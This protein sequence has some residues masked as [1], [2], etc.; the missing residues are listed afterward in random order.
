M[1]DLYSLEQEHKDKLRNVLR[2]FC[3]D[4]RLKPRQIAEQLHMTAGEVTH[5]L[6]Q[7]D[8]EQEYRMSIRSEKE[9]EKMPKTD[10][11]SIFQ[12][13]QEMGAGDAAKVLA[14]RYG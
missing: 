12:R 4:E 14:A 5:L 11:A 1:I 2:Q 10:M 8:I 6:W 3:V 7:L 13:M 9:P